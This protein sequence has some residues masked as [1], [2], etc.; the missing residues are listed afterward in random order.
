[1][2][3]PVLILTTSGFWPKT[4]TALLYKSMKEFL[5]AS[6]SSPFDPFFIDLFRADFS[7]RKFGRHFAISLGYD[8]CRH[9]SMN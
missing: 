3:I 1:M 9:F 4:I 6:Y 7:C 5:W 2:Y 8:M